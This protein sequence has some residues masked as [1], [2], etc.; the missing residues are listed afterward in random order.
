MNDPTIALSPAGAGKSVV[1]IVPHHGRTQA[2]DLARRLAQQFESLGAEVRIPSRDAEPT[3][4]MEWATDETS[5]A[6]GMTVAL[7]IGGDGTM[8]R[9]VDLVGVGDVPV[10]GINVGQLGYLTALTPLEV[11]ERGIEMLTDLL[12]GRFLVEE[13]M[14]L[15]VVVDGHTVAY[16]ALNEAVVEK[17]S[18]G[19]T[20]RLG[21]AFD[22]EPFT[23][24]SADGL[25]VA[26]P[27]GS[28]AYAF[29]ARGPVVSPAIRAMIV[30]PVSAH[31]LFDRSLVLESDQ[32]VTVTVLDRRDASLFVDGRA[33]GSLP[34]G[35]VVTV[36]EGERPARFITFTERHFH[37]I[38]RTKF[39]LAAPRPWNPPS[40][41]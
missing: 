22:D 3:G 32:R 24:Y 5:F 28:T 26:T 17:S 23:D 29:S 35:S 8:L 37:Q 15:S 33:C 18:A 1:G 20:V 34:E 14:T 31:M 13:R 16:R 27:T 12:A 4:L 41:A 38:L 30:V 25:I 7:S 40:R 9:T 36:T 21:V 2:H 39:G 6:K 19:N 11:D 10:L